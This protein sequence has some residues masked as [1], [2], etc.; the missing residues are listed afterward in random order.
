MCARIFSISDKYIGHM[1]TESKALQSKS[2]TLNDG[3]KNN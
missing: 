1:M 3:Q 2:M